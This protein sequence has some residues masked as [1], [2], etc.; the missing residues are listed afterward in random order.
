MNGEQV[1]L[2]IPREDALGDET[3]A[4]WPLAG[5]ILARAAARMRWVPREEAEAADDLVQLIPCTTVTDHAGRRHVFQRVERGR[6]DLRGRASLLIGGHID[7]E[8]SGGSRLD[9][10]I[11]WTLFRETMEELEAAHPDRVTRVGLIADPHGPDQGRHLAVAHESAFTGPLRPRP[12]DE[13][14]KRSG[15]E[16]QAGL[17]RLADR[18]DPWSKT[19]LERRILRPGDR[20]Q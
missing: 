15:W 20:G 5:E 14:K 1:V 16:D 17:E 9:L 2:A 11:A 19:L 7:L 6:S 10:L 13:F 3:F 12:G 4:P 18:M 8:S